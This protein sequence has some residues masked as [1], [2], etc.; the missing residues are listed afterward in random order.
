MHKWEY[1]LIEKKQKIFQDSQK[2]WRFHWYRQPDF[3]KKNLL[4]DYF[5]ALY[6]CLL[7]RTGHILNKY[8]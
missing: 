8:I 7:Q 3:K 6:L 5:L 2:L 4:A 1:K